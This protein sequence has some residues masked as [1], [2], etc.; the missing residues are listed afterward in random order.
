M[1][2]F[3]LLAGRSFSILLTLNISHKLHYNP[4]YPATMTSNFIHFHNSMHIVSIEGNESSL[5]LAIA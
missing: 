5:L 2:I 1:Y 4:L 3:L